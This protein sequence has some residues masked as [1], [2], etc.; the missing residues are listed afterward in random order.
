MTS[1]GDLF[2][3]EIALKSETELYKFSIPDVG[4]ALLRGTRVLA[5]LQELGR[6]LLKTYILKVGNLL[7]GRLAF[8]V[9]K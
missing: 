3:A 4:F 5:Y 8:P 1:L 2:A 7:Y 6:K 9:Q